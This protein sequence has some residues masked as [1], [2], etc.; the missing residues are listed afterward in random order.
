M[1]F[2]FDKCDL[3]KLEVPD[4]RSAKLK[5]GDNVIAET[6]TS[7]GKFE[8]RVNRRNN[9][10]SE[11]QYFF[12]GR[13]LKP[14]AESEVPKEARECLKNA[15]RTAALY[16]QGIDISTDDAAASIL[17][18]SFAPAASCLTYGSCASTLNGKL[19]CCAYAKCWI[20]GGSFGE[21]F[22][23]GIY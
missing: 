7:H 5:D 3:F 2:G 10:N 20:T 15:D 8:A 1:G 16:G 18:A 14:T 11:P 13:L 19:Q 23:C 4:P 9:V 12:N 21:S 22:H 17:P 6:N